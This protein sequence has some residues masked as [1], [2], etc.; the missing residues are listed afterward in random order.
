MAQHIDAA[1]GADP[2]VCFKAVEEAKQ[3]ER[4]DKAMSF[5]RVSTQLKRQRR[6]QTLRSVRPQM[7]NGAWRVNTPSIPPP[8]N[9]IPTDW[10]AGAKFKERALDE[11]TETIN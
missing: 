6:S 3:L 10:V 7:N 11:T 2:Y 1:A 8:R 5:K 4:D 9:L